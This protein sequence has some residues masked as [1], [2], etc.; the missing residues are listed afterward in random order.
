MKK[1]T[2]LYLDS[3]LVEKAKRENINIS[4]LA[5]DA[6][7]KALDMKRPVTV[8]EHVQKILK[9]ADVTNHKNFYQETYLLPFQIESLTLNKIGPFE[10]F[11]TR[12]SRDRVNIIYGPN[13]SGK[14]IILRSILFAL[15]RR[16]RHFNERVSSGGTIKLK[17]FPNQT[18]I[19]I[20]DTENQDNMTKGYRCLMADAPIARIARKMVVP[21]LNELNCLGIQIIITALLDDPKTLPE[22]MHIISLSNYPHYR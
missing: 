22:N 6:L 19:A 15:G 7:K 17:L 21:L 10:K 3:D 4:R 18:S 9:D 12:F 14:S 8:E 13:G 5:E 20:T 16:H 1:N 2:L 11:E